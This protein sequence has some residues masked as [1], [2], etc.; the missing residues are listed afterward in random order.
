MSLHAANRSVSPQAHSFVYNYFFR[1]ASELTTCIV[2]SGGEPQLTISANLSPH[3][4]S[5]MRLGPFLGLALLLLVL[6]VGGFVVFHVASGLIHI[7]L[8]FAI[9]SVVVHFFTGGTRTA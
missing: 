2:P 7:L 6:W 4:V 3:G 9:I 8:L 1:F 5:K